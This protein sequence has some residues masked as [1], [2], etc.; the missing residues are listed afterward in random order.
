MPK[1]GSWIKHD[2]FGVGR[3]VKHVSITALLDGERE[4]ALD[5]RLV[6]QFYIKRLE[7]LWAFCHNRIRRVAKPRGRP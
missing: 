7:L 6:V 4:P 2:L 1:L 5:H 3:V